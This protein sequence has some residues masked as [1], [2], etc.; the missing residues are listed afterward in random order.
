MRIKEHSVYKTLCLVTDVDQCRELELILSKLNPL[1]PVQAYFLTSVLTYT[2]PLPYT[3]IHTHSLSLSLSSSS[4]PLPLFLYLFQQ[5]SRSLGS[6]L[7][8]EQGGGQHRVR[9]EGPEVEIMVLFA[10][11]W[12]WKG[13]HMTSCEP[14]HHGSA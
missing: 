2:V 12:L 10:A 13:Q 1:G 3:Y 14:Q 5:V 11:G 8:E 6:K 9:S 7:A 4:S